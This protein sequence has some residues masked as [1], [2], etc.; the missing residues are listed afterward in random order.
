[1]A[2]ESESDL[3]LPL[4]EMV[5]EF[6]RRNKDADPETLIK[7]FPQ[8]NKE[9]LKKYFREYKKRLKNQSAP[10]KVVKASQTFIMP[11]FVPFEQFTK[12]YSFPPYYGLYMWQEECYEV[13]EN[14]KISKVVVPRDHGKSILLGGYCEHKM[15]FDDYDVLYLGWTDRRK[16][17][18]ENV[19]NYFVI[20]DGLDMN[21]A[22]I[23][24]PYHFRI[25][26]G[27]RFDTY[28]ITSKDTLGKHALG[29]QDRFDKLTKED[30]EGLDIEFTEAIKEKYMAGKSVE[31]KLLIIIDDPIDE[32]FRQERWK[33]TKLEDKFNS[34]IANINPDKLII[35]GT[36]KFEEDFFYFID[37][38]YRDKMGTY[39]R[40][41][42][43]C[44][45]N[46][47]DLDI[48]NFIDFSKINKE[49]PKYQD[50]VLLLLEKAQ[51]HPCY[52]P[53]LD[54]PDPRFK[55]HAPPSEN[56]LCPE[57]WT[58]EQLY[59]KRKEIGEYW[60]YAEYE[61]EPH[62]ITGAVWDK[63]YYGTHWEHWKF[64]N[65]IGIFIDRATTT[66]VGSSWTGITIAV[67]D[68]ENN[69]LV[70]KDLTG[71]YDF[72]DC[73]QVVEDQYTW[74]KRTFLNT[75]FIVVVEKQG[76]GDDFISSAE[77]RKF[78]FAP[79]MRPVHQSKD[80]IE[81]IKDYLRVPINEGQVRFLDTL[82]NSE[83]MKEIM[84]F[85]YPVRLDA[86]D[87][88]ATGIKEMEQ[89]PCINRKEQL[90]RLNVSMEL[91]Y[92][93]NIVQRSPIYN[94]PIQNENYIKQKYGT[95]KKVR[96]RRFCAY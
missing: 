27:G 32:T 26:N 1:L 89:I 10:G 78:K 38:K 93:K 33:E 69:K 66:N 87:S 49:D 50:F 70:I 88:L 11:K 17:V 60:W 6:L 86:I 8:A 19:Y 55:P 68:W 34:T 56:L 80:K 24:S 94:N 90:E 42:H 43:L 40:R 35:A 37:L 36:R 31:R 54:K 45:P 46:I 29:V 47:E 96:R 22:K 18:A 71:Q 91:R 81:R 28:L 73:L 15:D 67:R 16:D 62:P 44:T 30:L 53:K 12:V 75:K 52:N 83:L 3:N 82:R 92:A 57:R 39:E 84:E 74:I 76:G 77:K 51:D 20:T 85:P 79:F 58:E 72:E 21:S 48:F 14:N 9:T 13:L 25:K 61:G 41:T 2:V 63:V 23:S 5:S 95:S 59:E 7:K 64:Y 4:K 65:L